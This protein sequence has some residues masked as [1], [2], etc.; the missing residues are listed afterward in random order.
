MAKSLYV[1]DNNDEM[2][3]ALNFWVAGLAQVAI[4]KSDRFTIAISGGSLPS[5]LGA[6]LSTNAT[7]DWSKWHV[8]FADERCVPLCDPE[9]NYD[10]A[11]KHLFSKVSIPASNIYSIRNALVNDPEAAA[12]DYAQQLKS[13]FFDASEGDDD[14]TKQVPVFD[15]ILLGVGP[16]G[17]T[18]SL[19]PS[20]KL[21]DERS[22]IVASLEDSPK[23]PPSRITL[24]YTVLNA[25][26]AIAFIATGDSKSD[27]IHRIIDKGENLPSGRVKPS[28]GELYWF[29][30]KAAVKMLSTKTDH[31]TL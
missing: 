13:V 24:T 1:F 3:E 20:H 2:S 27:V 30:D 16:D 17:H 25:A 11:R 18:C 31:F 7:I 4:A 26:S 5:I 19:F 8:F 12:K 29:F 15:L 22:K 23:P 21:L 6:K 9:S 10:L 28:N 14:C